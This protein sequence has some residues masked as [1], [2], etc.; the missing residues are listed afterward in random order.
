MLHVL[1]TIHTLALSRC[2]TL[3]RSDTLL[4]TPVHAPFLRLL[5]TLPFLSC[6][7][8]DQVLGLGPQPCEVD[9]L[10]CAHAAV[11][12]V[13]QLVRRNKG[14]ICRLICD[15]KGTRF[16][17]AFGVPGQAGGDDARRAVSACLG[18]ERGLQELNSTNVSKRKLTVATGVTTIPLAHANRS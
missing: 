11:G 4:C 6:P 3:A 18:I 10:P 7:L 5:L 17:I 2:R 8:V 15:D 13:Q 9:D 12:K 14:T 1:P 16:L